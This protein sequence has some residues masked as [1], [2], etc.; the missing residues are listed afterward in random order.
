MADIMEETFGDL[1]YKAPRSEDCPS[2]PSPA[3]LMRKILVKGKKLKKDLEEDEDEDGEVSD[4]DEA[5]EMEEDSKVCFR[6]CTCQ[7]QG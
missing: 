1:L 2:L 6:T 4:E 5:D 3:K 7:I